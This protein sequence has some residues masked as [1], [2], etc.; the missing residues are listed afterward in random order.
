MNCEE[1]N[2]QLASIQDIEHLTADMQ[3]HIEGCQSCREMYYQLLKLFQ[4]VSEERAVKV[5]PFI[6]TRILA[7]IEKSSYS[8]KRIKTGLVPVLSVVF[9][10]LGFFSA[11][12]FIG[13]DTISR[14][15][16]EII[17][18]EYYLSENPGTLL[19]ETWLNTYQNE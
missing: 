9:M 16:V 13:T 17:A 4:Y 11:R 7:A 6:N 12:W 8:Q 10:L 14:E 1:F 3:H 19:E 18:S 5:S 2:N 15:S